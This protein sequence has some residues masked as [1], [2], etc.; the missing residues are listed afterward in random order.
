[1]QQVFS[2]RGG[3]NF[4]RQFRRRQRACRDDVQAV[5]RAGQ[6]RQF[7]PFD[8]DQRILAQF[9]FDFLRKRFPVNGQ[10]AARRNGRLIRRRHN[11]RTAAAHFFVQQADG[12][13]QRVVGTQGI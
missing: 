10:S 6:I 8:C 12:I 13:V 11:Q 5:V 9:F 3:L 7:A 2:A 4:F 1:M